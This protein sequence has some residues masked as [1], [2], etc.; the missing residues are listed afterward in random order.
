MA[1]SS[2]SDPSWRWRIVSNAGELVEE[3]R[4][5]FL[6][7]AAAVD[8]GRARARELDLRDTSE[9]T[10]PYRRGRPRGR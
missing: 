4:Q 2:P 8:E 6:S 10:F 5:V 9:R 1:F 3:S 7:I